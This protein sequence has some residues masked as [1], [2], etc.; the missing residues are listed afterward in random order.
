MTKMKKILIVFFS[1]LLVLSLAGC[2]GGGAQTP[3]ANEEG[4]VVKLKVYSAWAENNAMNVH[5][6][7]FI[8]KVKEKSN[9]TLEIVWGGGPEAI[10]TQQLAEA[11]KNQMVDIAWTAHTYNIS[12]IPVLEGVKLST[13]DFDELRTSGGF[14]FL[15]KLYQ[16]K[17]NNHLLGH[18]MGGLEYNLYTTQKE[19]KSIADFKGMTIRG[20]PAYQAF[21]EGLGAAVV[22]TAPGEVYQALERNVVQGYGWPSVGIID[23]GWHEVT[24]YCIEPS[25]YKVDGAILVSDK[26]WQTLNDTQK[27][28]LTDAAKEIEIET[29]EYYAKKIAEE[30]QIIEQT[31]VKTITLPDDVAAEYLKIAYDSAWNN[32]IK[33]APEDGPKL[34]ELITKK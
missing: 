5:L 25:F 18:T 33:N 28:A 13:Y 31:G 29:K 3:P 19:V 9:G 10:P 14:D 30:R 2:G 15:D 24:G 7:P 8:E 23:F 22:N 27:A 16:E 6:Q 26:V 21:V 32:V 34:R 17:M 1:V 20:T 4:K 11:I 12:H